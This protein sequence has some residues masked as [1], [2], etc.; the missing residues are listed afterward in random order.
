M[1][2]SHNW[3]IWESVPEEGRLGGGRGPRDGEDLE[4]SAQK[5]VFWKRHNISKREI[6]KLQ[7]KSHGQKTEQSD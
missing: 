3:M 1:A 6:W 7:A 5:R 4:R 2:P